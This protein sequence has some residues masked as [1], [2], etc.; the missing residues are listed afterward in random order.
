M[1][2]SE[3]V[4][5]RERLD[6]TTKCNVMCQISYWFYG[7][8]NEGLSEGWSFCITEMSDESIRGNGN[9]VKGTQELC[10]IFKTFL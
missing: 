10:T 2:A 4:M 1:K 8:P 5:T 3:T 7:K 9:W 6:M